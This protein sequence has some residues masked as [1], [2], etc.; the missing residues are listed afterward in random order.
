MTTCTTGTSTTLEELVLEELLPLVEQLLPLLHFH[1]RL[2]IF[3]LLGKLLDFG[4]IA[5]LPSSSFVFIFHRIA[6]FFLL[7]FLHVELDG[8]ADDF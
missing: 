5:F 6:H 3:L 4:L 1:L 8:K 7:R 2:L